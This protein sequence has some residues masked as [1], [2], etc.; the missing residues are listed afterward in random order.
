MAPPAVSLFFGVDF[1]AGTAATPEK[2]DELGVDILILENDIDVTENVESSVTFIDRSVENYVNLVIDVS[3]SLTDDPEFFPELVAALNTLV[4]DLEPGGGDPDVYV[5]MYVFGRSVAEYV[6]FTRDFATVRAALDTLLNEPETVVDLAGGGQG[7]DLFEG[8][9][10]GIENTQRIRELRDAVTWGGVL[11][12]GTIVII[13]DGM[14]SSNG[15]LDTGL[16]DATRNHVI[17]V[18]LGLEINDNQL[19][20]IG[21]DGNFLAPTADDLAEAFAAISTRVR[22]YPLRSQM[23]GYCSSTT[24]GSPTVT[25]SLQGGTVDHVGTATCQFSA[26]LFASEAIECNEET[27]TLEC[28]AQEC[29]GLTACG[30]CAHDE[31]CD[32]G[33]CGA[34]VTRNDTG[35]NCLGNPET[36]RQMGGLCVD[37]ACVTPAAPGVDHGDTACDP[38]CEPGAYICNESPPGSSFCEPAL[39]LGTACSVPLDCDSL[40]CYF[41]DP[42]NPFDGRKCLP[43]ARVYDHCGTED[44]VCED[45]SY[46]AGSTCR[47]KFVELIQ[48]SQHHECRRGQCQDFGMGNFCSGPAACYWAWDEKVPS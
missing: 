10:E 5:G 9:K 39:P 19:R 46:C 48:C 24:E 6:P 18:G 40:N 34:P 16:I 26:D 13:T 28:G 43:E 44:A 8:T 17:S 47:S 36:C 14:D 12:T 32:G 45:G 3:E 33:F 2:L 37:N 11:T 31:C 15:M 27:F 42:D 25:V 41:V 35:V 22:E 20:S 7:T 1:C 38:G 29:G 23:L 4:D 30:S 21:R